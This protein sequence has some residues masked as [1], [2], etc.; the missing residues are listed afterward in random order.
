[1][2]ITIV[3]ETARCAKGSAKASAG[4]PGSGGFDMAMAAV[5]ALFGPTKEL[6]SIEN[7]GEPLSFFAGA[8]GTGGGQERAV[9]VLPDSIPNISATV[10]GDTGAAP[11]GL[12]SNAEKTALEIA[13][14]GT[15]TPDANALAAAAQIETAPETAQEQ[16]SQEIT[17][18]AVAKGVIAGVAQMLPQ[19]DQAGE[20]SPAASGRNAEI[21]LKKP[22]PAPE[23]LAPGQDATTPGGSTKGLPS[24]ENAGKPLSFFAGAAGTGGGQERAAAVL[25]D[26]IPNRNVTV[27]GEPAGKA[28]SGP[29]SDAAKTASEKTVAAIITPDANARTTSEQVKTMA[30]TLPGY[31]TG[32]A[33]KVEGKLNTIPNSNITAGEEP[34]RAAPPGLSNNAAKTASEKTVA[35]IITPDA[36]ARTTSEQVKTMA[37]T[38]PGYGA[39]EAEKV[40]G[41]LNDALSGKIVAGE[42]GPAGGAKNKSEGL[43]STQGDAFKPDSAQINAAGA[44]PDS[45]RNLKA[46]TLPEL[47]DVVLQEIKHFYDTRKGEPA[48]IQIK[49]EPESLGKLTIRIY[50]RNGELNAH[51]YTGSDH[52][53]EILQ[54]SLQ[55]LRESLSRQELTLNQA[56]VFVGGENSDGGAGNRTAHG[57]RRAEYF[58]NSRPGAA[59]SRSNLEPDNYCRLDSEYPGV[60]Y[61]I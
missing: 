4:R 24:I 6:P 37:Q 17:D 5:M 58:P 8:A 27:M 23:N 32:E 31:G 47:K 61:L 20:E 19:T 34:A 7:A 48:R 28:P 36:N 43:N 1:M 55:Q 46:V 26:A 39:G 3:D 13:F 15:F 25:P 44:L 45:A 29:A 10:E 33:E 21:A 14:A 22:G 41:K 9:A 52:V 59:A 38:L 18:T 30:Q 50:Y 60:N 42:T 35:A 12:T 53:K 40:V 2:Q 51:F 54:G 49:L 16:N 56:F 11:P 57:N